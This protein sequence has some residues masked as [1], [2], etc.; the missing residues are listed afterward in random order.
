MRELVCYILQNV[1]SLNIWSSGEEKASQRHHYQASDLHTVLSQPNLF[2]DIPAH[3]LRLKLDCV[4]AEFIREI[5]LPV[6]LHA[7]FN[8][9]LLTSLKISA[10]HQMWL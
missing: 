2:I 6:N 9:V 7:G 10:F 1:L 3:S 5:T 4:V 8:C